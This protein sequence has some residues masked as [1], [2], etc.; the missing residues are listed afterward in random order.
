MPEKQK[1]TRNLR[2]ILSADVKGDNQ[3]SS[4]KIMDTELEWL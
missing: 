2:A 1:T 4:N 3:S